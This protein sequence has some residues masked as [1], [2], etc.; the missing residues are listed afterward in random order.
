MLVCEEQ[1]FV[2]MAPKKTGSTSFRT[3]LSDYHFE[4]KI[5]RDYQFSNIKDNSARLD[6]R[7]EG[8]DWKHVCELPEKFSNFF[9]FATVRNPYYIEASRYKHDIKHGY[10]SESF[11]SFLN[12][13]RFV[14]EPPSLYRKLKQNPEY[15]PPPGCVKYKLDAVI[16]LESIN[17]DIT[18]LPFYRHNMSIKHINKSS[19]SAPFYTAETAKIVAEVFAEDFDFFGYDT[20]SWKALGAISMI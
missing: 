14:N 20:N 13:L 18:K 17:E 11:S 1:K 12:K 6:W 7:S 15:V 3:M 19:I 8:A 10:T 9:I 5:W 4:T 2:Y 16:K